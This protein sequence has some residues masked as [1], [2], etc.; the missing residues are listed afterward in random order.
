MLQ[1]TILRQKAKSLS[2]LSLG[3]IGMQRAC[4]VS[5]LAFLAAWG[6]SAAIAQ[7]APPLPTWT[8]QSPVTSPPPRGEAAMAYDAS[9]GQVMLFGGSVPAN[10]GVQMPLNDTW[11]WNGSTWKQLTGFLS[12]SP[13][14]GA[15]MASRGSGEVVLFGGNAQNQPPGGDTLTVGDTWTWNG[16][17][18][19]PHYL[20]SPQPSPRYGAA[21]A[22]HAGT[23]KVVLFGGNGNGYL[24]GDTWTWNGANWTLLTPLTSPPPRYGA[25][26]AYDAA[27]GQVVLFGGNGIGTL[28]GDTW[29]W[30]GTTWTQQFPLTSPSPRS[31]A[32][33]AY[34]ASTGQVVLF[35]GGGNGDTWTWNGSTWT[36]LNSPTNPSPRLGTAMAYDAAIGQI[37]L[38]GG[39]GNSSYPAKGDTW[40]L[41]SGQAALTPSVTVLPNPASVNATQAMIVN[42]AVSGGTGNPTPTG[43]VTVSSSSYISSATLLIGGSTAITVP[44]GSLTIGTNT[45][46]VTYMGDGSYRPA[47]GSASVSITA[48]DAPTP[49]FS[50][51]GG[52]YSSAQTV[53][54]S[55]TVSGAT[56]YYTTNGATPTT[57]STIYSGPITVSASVT[58]KAMAVANYYNPSAIGSASYTISSGATGGAQG[59]Y[60]GS[61]SNGEAFEG[62]VLP[63]NTFYALYG[64]SS[65]NVFNIMGMITGQGNSSNGTYSASITDYY[66]SGA[67]YTGSVSASYVSGASINGKIFDSGVGTLSFTGAALPT[68]QYNYNLPASLSTIVGTWNGL[69]SEESEPL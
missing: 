43:S 59:A 37:V 39:D 60:F 65:G 24:S 44:A 5:L 25:S 22:Y 41:Q 56:I 18:W 34:D 63:N 50:P 36:H 68:S 16:S 53:N 27:T 23:G 1:S 4:A 48:L 19:S 26:M 11:T 29:T 46:T 20:L 64:T 62:I 57:G 61:T 28:C 15:S 13:R 45:L 52:T 49:S 54:I 51:S 12:P 21:M 31:G 35:G 10:L 69:S 30:N 38:F 17:S 42:V 67:T 58:L 3:R 40:T 6:R 2:L 47:T 33:M 9:T 55:N 8:Q 66:Y 7:S 14:Y 32:T